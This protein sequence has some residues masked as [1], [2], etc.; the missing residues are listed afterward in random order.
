[1]SPWNAELTKWCGSERKRSLIN[2]RDNGLHW[3]AAG[4]ASRQVGPGLWPTGMCLQVDHWGLDRL[5]RRR[6]VLTRILW[7]RGQNKHFPSGPG[8]PSHMMTD[9]WRCFT[10][11]QTPVEVSPGLNHVAQCQ[12]SQH[13][14]CAKSAFFSW[15]VFPPSFNCWPKPNSHCYLA[16][17]LG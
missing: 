3:L 5:S 2:A 9:S 6:G 1:M 8:E 7:A 10:K 16:V 13:V 4:R 11:T 12:S 14:L 17:L 15:P